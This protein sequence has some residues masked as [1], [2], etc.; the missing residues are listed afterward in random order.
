MSWALVKLGQLKPSQTSVV[1]L[2]VITLKASEKIL[3]LNEQRSGNNLSNYL[4]QYKPK[5]F[6]FFIGPEGGFS[7]SEREAL[8]IH[9]NV[10]SVYLPTNILKTETIVISAISQIYAI[11]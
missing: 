5:D 4:I 11:M 10:I 7:N 9:N 1:L 2:A 3:W 6:I 8:S